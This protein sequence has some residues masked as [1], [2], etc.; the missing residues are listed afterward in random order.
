MDFAPLYSQ[1]ARIGLSNT[2]LTPVAGQ[3]VDLISFA[4]GAPDPESFPRAELAEATERVLA[5]HS[6]QALQYGPFQGDPRFRRF[7][8]ERLN[9][10]E[11][12][13]LSPEQ[14]AVT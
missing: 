8:A 4:I 11:G 1:A 9:E 14:I 2:P 10:Q 6:A 12:L 13:T 5:Q 7:I 3:P